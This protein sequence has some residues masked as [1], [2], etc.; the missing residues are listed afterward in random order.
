MGLQKVT[1]DRRREVH[2][3]T[4][5]CDRSEMAQ[6][7]KWSSWVTSIAMDDVRDRSSQTL[8]PREPTVQQCRPYHEI[9]FELPQRRVRS[10]SRKPR[11]TRPLT[12]SG[13]PQ[14]WRRSN[15]WPPSERGLPLLGARRPK[16]RR[17]SARLIPRIWRMYLYIFEL[18]QKVPEPS[19]HPAM[20]A[21][22]N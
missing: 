9:A 21:N 3:R 17:E 5:G 12:D 22:R 2:W 6:H 20:P 11:A 10:P 15:A 7:D 8:Y 16:Q 4:F 13:S 14:A 1:D 19:N 18:A